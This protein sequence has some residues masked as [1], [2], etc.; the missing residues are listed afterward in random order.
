MTNEK[1]SHKG[2]NEKW[3][4]KPTCHKKIKQKR[5]K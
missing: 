3:L 2:K 5:K 4:F 1:N